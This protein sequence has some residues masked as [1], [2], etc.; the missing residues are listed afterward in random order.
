MERSKLLPDLTFSYNIMGMRGT[1]AD[2]KTY[3]K[4]LRFQSGQIGLAIPIF[5]IGQSSKIKAAKANEVIAS[6]EYALNLQ[7][8]QNAYQAAMAQYLKFEETVQ[9]FEQTALQNAEIIT[10]TAHQQFLNGDINYLEWVLLLNQA[11]AIQSD[12][13]EAVKNRNNSIA[14]LNFYLNN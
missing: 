1:G 8:L 14:E 5:A 10:K 4:D 9:Y 7:N 12:Y 11:T 13:I 6:N 2:D 3:N